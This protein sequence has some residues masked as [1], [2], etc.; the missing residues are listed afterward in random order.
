MRVEIEGDADRG[1]A[2]AFGHDFRMDAGL[3]GERGVGVAQVVQTDAG[4]IE[5]GDGQFERSRE[6]LREDRPSDLVAEY[7]VE[8]AIPCGAD[9][10]ALLSLCLR[11]SF[12]AA[13][14]RLRL[15]PRI[16]L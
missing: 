1:V 12:S 10:Q 16:G 13:S 3:E 14:A 7:E 11:C 2:E 9:R 4:D 15:N 8:F 5:S 6:R